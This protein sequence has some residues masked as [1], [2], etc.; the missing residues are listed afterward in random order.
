MRSRFAITAVCAAGLLAACEDGAPEQNRA[1]MQAANPLSDQL[2]GMSELYRNLGLRRALMDSGQRCK[3]VDRAAYQ[4]QY[5][6][7]AMWVARCSDTGDWQIHIAPTGDVQVRQCRHAE[8]LGL[9]V[10]SVLPPKA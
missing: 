6:T 1:V 5:K 2:K 4:E 9:P 10:C 7:M 8:Q 3:K